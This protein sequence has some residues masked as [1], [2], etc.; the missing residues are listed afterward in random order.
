MVRR[1]PPWLRRSPLVLQL[2]LVLLSP[3]LLSPSSSLDA[4]S[5]PLS[6]P[7]APRRPFVS[8]LVAA[9]RRAASTALQLASRGQGGLVW[10]FGRTRRRPHNF[11]APW[12]ARGPAEQQKG[13]REE[14]TGQRG[15]HVHR[16]ALGESRGG[17]R[18]RR[19]SRSSFSSRV[20][21]CFGGR[22]ERWL[23]GIRLPGPR[24]ERAKGTP[25]LD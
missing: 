24:E 6:R 20:C 22:K 7:P 16:E 11:V 10:P 21:V 1:L 15:R 4:F 23:G 17:E 25:T 19:K 3:P 8:L 18:G 13:E 2:V 12:S 14:S 9:S 5:R